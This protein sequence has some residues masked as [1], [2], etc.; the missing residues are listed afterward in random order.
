MKNYHLA[1]ACYAIAGLFASCNSSKNEPI[2]PEEYLISSITSDDTHELFDYDASGQISKWEYK[3]QEY[4]YKASYSYIKEENAIEIASEEKIAD[5]RIFNE[6]LYLNQNGIADHAEGTVVIKFSNGEQM[7]KNYTVDFHYNS[8]CQ[9]AEVNIAEKSTDETGWEAS[10]ALEWTA[11]LEWA[12]NNLILYREYTNPRHPTIEKEYNYFGL[13]QVKYMPIVQGCI[14]RSYYLPLQYQGILGKQSES[15]VKNMTIHSTTHFSYDIRTT[16][17][18]S[19]V[20]RYTEIRNGK[21]ITYTIKWE[22]K[23]K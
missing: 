11:E 21:E 18:T 6:K 7:M 3:E 17:Y 13:Q 15:L 12:D 23:R 5:T 4:S 1:I 2:N 22:P 14:V 16:T 10:K 19:N 8:S 20:E 9:L